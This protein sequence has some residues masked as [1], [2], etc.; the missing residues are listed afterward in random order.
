MLEVPSLD[1]SFLTRRGQAQLV[2]AARRI[3]GR[4]DA[5][6]NVA[7]LHLASLYPD[8]PPTKRQRP[9]TLAA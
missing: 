6:L 5:A 3:F 9:A 1:A 8:G 7:N 4:F 2:A